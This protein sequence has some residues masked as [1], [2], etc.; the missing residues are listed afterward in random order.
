VITEMK[1]HRYYYCRGSNYCHNNVD[2]NDDVCKLHAVVQLTQL[3]NGNIQGPTPSLKT[4][5]IVTNIFL[6]S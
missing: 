2:Y 6:A 3:I 5:P 4:R 1:G